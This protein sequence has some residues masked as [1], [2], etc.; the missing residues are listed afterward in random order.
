MNGGVFIYD[1]LLLSYYYVIVNIII[2]YQ[3]VWHS[4]CKLRISETVFETKSKD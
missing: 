3:M 2:M 1:R 4:T